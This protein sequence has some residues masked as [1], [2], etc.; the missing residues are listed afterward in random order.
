MTGTVVCY[1]G[2]LS[3]GFVCYDDPPYVYKNR[4]VLAGLSWAGW[5]YA[6]TSL[7]CSNWHPLTWLSLELDASLW[8]TNPCG[9]HATNLVL[10][11]LN[12]V[13]VFVAL[14][15]LTNAFYRS[16]YVAAFFAVHPLH[17]ESVAWIAERKDVLSTFFLLL[18]I[19]AYARY[20][21]RPS[22]IRYL[23]VMTTL[24]LGL[25]AKPMLVTL[26]VLLILLDGWPLNRVRVTGMHSANPR[27]PQQ[28]LR[29][30]IFEKVP[31]LTLAVA[32]GLITMLAQKNTSLYL[33][34]VPL[35]ARLANAF[36]ACFWYLRKTFVPTN[37]IVF[38]P[39]PEQHLS[40]TSVGLGILVTAGISLW[41]LR[42]ASEKP[43]LC[44]GWAW[45][46][47]S[48]LPVIGILQVGGQ[49]YADRYTYI[50][51]IGLFISI[52]W[53]AHSWIST[54]KWRRLF[55]IPC[56]IAA[57]IACGV[58]T[59]SQVAIWNNSVK[60]WTHAIEVDPDNY[61]AHGHLA[62]LRYVEG[63]FQRT[64][65]HIKRSLQSKRTGSVGKVYSNWGACLVAINRAAEAEEKFRMALTIDPYQE[66]ALSEL[67]RIL[68]EQGRKEEAAPFAARFANIQREKQ[69]AMQAVQNPNTES[70]QLILGK[71]KARQ[72]NL[73][74]A[75]LHFRNAIR[76]SPQSAT[77]YNNLALAQA[78]L[79][80]FHEA[81]TNFLQTIELNP[82]LA[83]A[84]FNLAQLL[85]AEK[86]LAG[87]RKHFAEAVRLDPS[88]VVA[89]QNLD[90]LSKP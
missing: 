69:L 73:E 6:W 21:A 12:A 46:V 56:V 13:L 42:N 1:W 7:E 89:K 45:F 31:L 25:L 50:P 4:I 68:N 74:S 86:D 66:G 52:V 67:A 58:L 72:G 20:A 11:C 36:N 64:I 19:V 44:V 41:V 75:I 37:L 23:P 87:A 8:G 32:D 77:A 85:E 15:H 83:S 30:L 49:A 51:H 22:L 84:H 38:Y 53:E 24:S 81:K 14:H 29:K 33:N 78:Q 28:T 18:T 48:L 5:K 54:A 71:Q 40:W 62:D 59:H 65:E 61:V 60:L 16:A 43:Y 34:D 88:D 57:L 82:K 39:H 35:V 47:T 3:N 63:D 27:F 17:V 76:F 80:Q 2:V 79:R 90:R 9:Y 70:A 10:H 55:G 26:P